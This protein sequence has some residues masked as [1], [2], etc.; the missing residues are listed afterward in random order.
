MGPAHL[1]GSYERGNVPLCG[2]HLHWLEDQPGQ[3]GNFRDSEK[4]AADTL[5]QE[6]WREI[7]TDG[8]GNLAALPSQRYVSVHIGWV[9][10]LKFQQTDPGR[11]IDLA[12]WR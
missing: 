3:I 4:S 8:P 9:P 1:G 2:N 7:S 12:S 11:G 6:E 10:R 5:Q